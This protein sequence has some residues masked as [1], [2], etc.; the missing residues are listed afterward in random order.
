MSRLDK[1][2]LCMYGFGVMAVGGG[3]N[4]MTFNYIP[5]EKFGIFLKNYID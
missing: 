2:I 3:I 1:L 5:K 4:L